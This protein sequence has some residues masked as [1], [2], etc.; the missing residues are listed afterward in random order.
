MIQKTDRNVHA[1]GD[2][3][4]V[5]DYDGVSGYEKSGVVELDACLRT[6]L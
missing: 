6:R 3:R 2:L 4:G 1:H 5:K